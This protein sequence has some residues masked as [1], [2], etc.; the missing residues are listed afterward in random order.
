YPSPLQGG[1]ERILRQAIPRG[2]DPRRTAGLPPQRKRLLPS[3]SLSPFGHTPRRRHASRFSPRLGSR[4]VAA[5]RPALEER[6]YAI[7][8][9]FDLGD[10]QIRTDRKAQK[11]A[12]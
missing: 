11:F 8:D 3:F 5:D 12:R 10:R 1:L 4:I 7:G 6:T 2:C 9:V